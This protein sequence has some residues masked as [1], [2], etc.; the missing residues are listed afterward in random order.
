M[1][2]EGTWERD[3]AATGSAAKPTLTPSPVPSLDDTILGGEFEWAATSSR[4]GLAR[5]GNRA[6][7]EVVMGSGVEYTLASSPDSTDSSL[8]DVSAA[9]YRQTKP[10][11]RDAGEAKRNR[12]A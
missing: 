12:F 9:M 11:C 4:V 6:E 3:V 7:G 8:G 10:R 5:S 2:E 1:D